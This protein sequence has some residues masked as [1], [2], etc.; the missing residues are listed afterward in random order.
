MHPEFIKVRV[1]GAKSLNDAKDVAKSIANSPLVKTAI[2]GSD[3]NW[4]DCYGY[5]QIKC[6]N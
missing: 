6:R 2:A 3:A 1:K 4:E 5:R